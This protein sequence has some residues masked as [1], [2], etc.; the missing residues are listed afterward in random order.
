MS[1]DDELRVKFVLDDSDFRRDF[2]KLR[3][4]VEETGG[5]QPIGPAG[6]TPP[7]ATPTPPVAP[8]PPQVTQV[9][10]GERAEPDTSTF[11]SRI[12]QLER[13]VG[14]PPNAATMTTSDLPQ[15][16]NA[17]LDRPAFQDVVRNNSSLMHD[18]NWA[19]G[20]LVRSQPG[21]T[22]YDMPA[23][24]TERSAL[25]QVFKIIGERSIKPGWEQ[26]FT[27]DINRL[28]A[29]LGKL[30]VQ[31]TEV[32]SE[33]QRVYQS[34]MHTF[35]QKYVAQTMREGD[36][37]V[38]LE[39]GMREAGRK[40][41]AGR[42]D[43]FA[44]YERAG[45][46]GWFVGEVATGKMGEAKIDQITKYMKWAIQGA[47]KD[48]WLEAGE[49]QRGNWERRAVEKL[50]D[51]L[52]DTPEMAVT[53]P[54]GESRMEKRFK[55][56]IIYPEGGAPNDDIGSMIATIKRRLVSNVKWGSRKKDKRRTSLFREFMKKAVTIVPFEIPR[57]LTK[58]L[59][60]SYLATRGKD[61]RVIL[62]EWSNTL[63]AYMGEHPEFADEFL[64]LVNP[65]DPDVMQ[66][67]R[68]MF[69]EAAEEARVSGRAI[70]TPEELTDRVMGQAL[71]ITGPGRDSYPSAALARQIPG[72]RAGRG[73]AGTVPQRTAQL[74]TAMTAY[75]TELMGEE[76]GRAATLQLLGGPEEG[77]S[78]LMMPF[79]WKEYMGY[80]KERAKQM[81]ISPR[82]FST[83]MKE[84]EE[85][86]QPYNQMLTE[87]AEG[88]RRV[89]RQ[90]IWRLTRGG[91][92]QLR[93]ELGPDL[94][95]QVLG[96]TAIDEDQWIGLVDEIARKAGPESL[97][98]AQDGG[99]TW[100][101]MQMVAE[102]MDAFEK[103]TF[104][105]QPATGYFSIVRG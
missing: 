22:Y 65:F 18:L 67:L 33:G 6:T 53:S 51:E 97:I 39:Y 83:V 13:T 49:N 72:A 81:G 44:E 91:R 102:K 69:D 41:L 76:E 32:G 12:E 50:L 34:L 25:L 35:M 45:L 26:G 84:L 30:N 38:T 75:F 8:P 62:E 55:V 85:S 77:D 14:L 9:S 1:Y 57:V 59:A 78:A 31:T 48:R 29:Q 24:S 7:P 105:L 43:I 27:T 16:V 79:D 58:K 73:R 88:S 99:E 46:P 71:E 52:T 94:F 86:E 3:R 2:D 100:R 92:R 5:R 42:I 36:K 10:V 104:K 66:A 56:G 20:Y 40:G 23:G 93:R 54:T 70:G 19:V 60:E 17:M 98:M 68:N 37:D 95:D 90:K 74:R 47:A 64:S 28:T 61:T 101:K 21:K 87:K 103:L 63:S 4:D 11:I 82:L 15:V 96:Q 80:I 89:L